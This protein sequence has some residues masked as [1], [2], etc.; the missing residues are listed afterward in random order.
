MPTSRCTAGNSVGGRHDPWA[1]AFITP[2]TAHPN[3]GQPHLWAGVRE[4]GRRVLAFSLIPRFQLRSDDRAPDSLHRYPSLRCSDASASAAVRAMDGRSLRSGLTRRLAQNS[5]RY[6]CPEA[7]DGEPDDQAKPCRLTDALRLERLT[8]Q[9]RVRIPAGSRSQAGEIA[10]HD[11]QREPE[12]NDNY[13]PLSLAQPVNP[14]HGPTL[15]ALS[16]LC[17]ELSCR[18]TNSDVR[19]GRAPGEAR[20][21]RH[22]RAAASTGHLARHGLQSSRCSGYAQ[23]R[24]HAE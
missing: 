16:R 6:E 13:S 19:I 11:P 22:G 18:A 24:H 20:S 2:T 12:S 8:R 14:A 1:S 9:R 10:G 21:C 5:Q 7:Y 3:R 15:A 23:V 4:L 17:D